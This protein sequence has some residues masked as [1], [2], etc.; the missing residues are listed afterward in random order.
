LRH[1][2]GGAK[3]W[4]TT[5]YSRPIDRV[6]AAGG[7]ADSKWD[8]VTVGGDATFI[9]TTYQARVIAYVYVH[10]LAQ[11]RLGWLGAADD[12]PLAISGETQ[13]PGDDAQIEF[14]DRHPAIEVQAK[15]G[16]TG[17][18]KLQEV[19]ERLGMITPG[20]PS[21]Q[22][23]LTVNRPSSRKLYTEFAGDLER[24]RSGRR[25]GL[26]PETR[27]L[28]EQTADASLL[29]RLFVVPIDLDHPYD[30]EAHNVTR[31]LESVLEDSRQVAA[32]WGVLVN[33]A[34]EICARRLRRTRKELV[35]LL[36]GAEIKAKRPA[37][38][39]RWHRQLDFCKQ[40][41]EKRH[42]AAALT[43]LAKVEGE[44]AGVQV[45]P[46][47]RYRLAQ[48]RGSALLQLD[49]YEEAIASCRRAL[50]IDPQGPHALVTAAVAALN[51]GDIQQ[52]TALA[53]RAVEV[54]PEFPNAWGAKAQVAVAH[55]LALP[56]PPP[57]VADSEYYRAML[58]QLA[59]AGGDWSGVL[60][61]TAGLLA[62]GVRSPEVLFLR[63]NALVSIGPSDKKEAERERYREAERLVSDLVDTVADETH[64]LMRKGLI[65]RAHARR[66]LGRMEEAQAD[67]DRIRDIASDD[68]DAIGHA[69]RWKMESGD[70]AA[71]LEILRHPAVG[72]SAALL[73]LRARVLRILG[74][75]DEAYRDLDAA[76]RRIPDSQNPDG[77]RFSAAEVALD[78]EKGV[79]AERILGGVTAS[80]I[81]DA[82]YVALRGRIALAR[83]D[84]LAGVAQYEDAAA[85]DPG[86]QSLFLA[87]LGS[88]LLRMGRPGEAVAAF[89][90]ARDL[91]RTAVQL[92]AGALVDDNQLARAQLIVDGIAQSGP[93]PDWALGV[94]TD[95]ALRREDLDTAIEHLTQLV[96]HGRPSVQGRFELTRR[97]IERGRR[98]DA[99]PHLDGLVADR[100]LGPFERM[101][102]AQL[103]HAAGRDAEALPFAFQAFRDAPQDPRIHRA[104]IM[105][106][107]TT[108]EIP[109]A[110]TEVGPDTHVR[111]K[112]QEGVV[113]QHT[114]YA[115]LPIDP[116]RGEMSVD[117]AE[118]GGLLGKKVGDTIVRNVGTWQEQ[119]WKVDEILPA[120]V[121]AA[122][123]AML[124]YEERFPGQPF[125]L[126][127]FSIG[128]GT[129]VKDFAP[130]IASL[131]A[132]RASVTEVF[133]LYRERIPPL[134]AVAKLLG[135]NIT[136][137]MQHVIEDHRISG[138]LLVEWSD[139]EGQ[140]ESRSSAFEGTEVVLTR[141]AMK[142]SS[143]LGLL[144]LIATEYTLIAPRS[145]EREMEEEV[146]EAAR[147][148]AEGHRVIRSG[149]T[150][151]TA[152]ELEPGHPS[153][154]RQLDQ[155]RALC[156]WLRRSVKFEPR[157]LER[158]DPPGS[159]EEEARELMGHSSY[160]AVGLAQHRGASMYADDLGLR[161][162]VPKGGRGRSFSTIGLLFGLAERG[163]LSA[164]RRDSHL[165][166]LV[167]RNYA[168]V[169]P[170]PELLQLA[171][172]RE[173]ELG[174][175]GLATVFAVL[176]S[177][178]T[179][180]AEAARV[181][182]RVLKSTVTA[183]V[184]LAPLDKVTELAL[185][186]MS[187][188]WPAHLCASLVGR[189]AQEELSLLPQHLVVVQR[190]CVGFVARA[191][192]IANELNTH[193][194]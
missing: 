131:E 48:Q 124:H 125:F 126:T 10:I 99:G 15:H 7:A 69:A 41:L 45:E 25:D 161:R 129:S 193:G 133:T 12:T 137:V 53:D 104:F 139:K 128:D 158:I 177:G 138:P 91:P 19:V 154:V 87:E 6:V 136:G 186:A 103:L 80:G 82:N 26:K 50:D 105:L 118:V 30:P 184:I 187:T 183:P 144:D 14:G 61:L 192:K 162:F 180:V 70:H 176:A 54:A 55:G 46:F 38:D 117:A 172:R 83:G 16:L 58:A 164:E 2:P 23:V 159:R 142:T 140:A 153:L 94:A 96:K 173:A 18:A 120:I 88:L 181:I 189:A 145:L 74:D 108:G 20:A 86:H 106:T 56:K 190:T 68:R 155:A 141:S 93:L 109:R 3:S 121:S 134:G 101:E 179:A 148:A 43:V 59:Q 79:L 52:A 174:Q 168:F 95:I 122:Q 85:R 24:L 78:L 143:D 102:V 32:A 97:L 40:L 166:T 35:D 112:N 11:M 22:V 34:S 37:R 111:L 4:T 123:D 113:R 130:L 29:A 100:T 110:V 146:S 147:L 13:G 171:L 167:T 194:R 47:V 119:S 63:A 62:E 149:D 185:G 49:R 163:S 160:D 157:P 75:K 182:A 175:S 165:L 150:G 21:M 135:G 151:L 127:G 9:G 39:E 156:E 132:R 42:A 64:K 33:D 76:L 107:I 60:E 44:M 170:S 116:L 8:E 84:V 152:H 51:A 66:Q 17:G 188:R 169:I 36:A 65:L 115:H 71:A 178:E 92:L 67:L 1:G 114:I 73:M 31:L 90:K 98:E 57:I 72:E 28:L 81:T 5:W 77:M 89:D 27:R 191:V